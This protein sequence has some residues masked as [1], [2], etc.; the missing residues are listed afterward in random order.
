VQF[1]FQFLKEWTIRPITFGIF[2]EALNILGT[3]NVRSVYTDT[4]QPDF[5]TVGTHSDDW[6]ADPS[7]YYPPRQLRIGA[8]I[9]F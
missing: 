1:D 7:N 2:F 4:G 9:T 3:E 8:R 6:M 5:T